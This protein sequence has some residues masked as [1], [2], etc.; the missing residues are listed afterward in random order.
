MREREISFVIFP[1]SSEFCLFCCQFHFLFADVGCCVNRRAGDVASQRGELADGVGRVVL[2][3]RQLQKDDETDRGRQPI[4]YGSDPVGDGPSRDWEELRQESQSL[5][6]K[7][8][9]AH[10][11]RSVVLFS[12]LFLSYLF[13]RPCFWPFHVWRV[14]GKKKQDLN[15]ERRKRHGKVSSSNRTAFRTCIPKS[16]TICRRMFRPRSKAGKKMPT[17]RYNKRA[18]PCPDSNSIVP[19]KMYDIVTC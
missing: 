19:T 2:G 12:F 17:T 6:E 13:G 9:R 8:E 4:V 1:S 5:V 16:R 10:W 7:V 11:K 14:Y 18:T 3:A 15:T